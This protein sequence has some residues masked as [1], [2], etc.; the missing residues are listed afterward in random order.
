MSHLELDI[1]G[2]SIQ[3]PEETLYISTE[4]VYL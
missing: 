2:P 4:S 3:L 1:L